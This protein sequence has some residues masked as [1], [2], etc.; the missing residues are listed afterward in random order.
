MSRSRVNKIPFALGSDGSL[1][2]NLGTSFSAHDVAALLQAAARDQRPLFVGVTLTSAE[3]RKVLRRLD[4]AGAEAAA[5]LS[6]TAGRSEPPESATHEK[7]AR[8]R[9]VAPRA[10]VAK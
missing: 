1:L 10:K 4:N 3:K 8:A 5:L 9:K 2:L 7:P 6:G